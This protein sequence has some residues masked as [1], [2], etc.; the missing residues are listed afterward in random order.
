MFPEI[1]TADATSDITSIF[2]QTFDCSSVVSGRAA[3]GHDRFKECRRGDQTGGAQN[4]Y[5][6]KKMTSAQFPTM[7]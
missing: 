6:R 1:H 4:S 3:K 2:N 5:N 7:Q